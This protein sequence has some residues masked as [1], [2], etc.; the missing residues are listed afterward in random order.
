MQARCHPIIL[1]SFIAT[2]P[3]MGTASAEVIW[4]DFSVSYLKGQHYR[5]G[6]ATQDI[7]TFEHTAD[8]SWGDSFLFL[9]HIREKNGVRSN[10]AEWAPRWSA[11]KL[12][13]NKYAYGIISDVLL[14]TT[15][16]MSDLQTNFLYGFG[17]DMTVPGTQILQLNAYRRVNEQMDD[18]WQLTGAWGVPFQVAGADFMFDGF[19]DWS[20]TTK[21]QRSVFNTNIQL[22][23]DLKSYWSLSNSVYLGVEYV[24]WNN[25]FGVADSSALRTE[26]S[27]MNLLLKVHF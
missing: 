7:F 10:Y 8:T 5:L 1:T 27:N 4:Q 9:D 21:D 23:W 18:N 13:G 14:S 11:S 3:M 20:N 25:K 12:T 6:S 15:V 19:F 26:E 17:V 22:K 2:L 24:Y 16:E